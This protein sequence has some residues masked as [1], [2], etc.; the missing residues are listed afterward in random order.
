MATKAAA[1]SGD[2]FKKPKFFDGIVDGFKDFTHF[3]SDV[4]SEMRK[5]VTPSPKEVRVT[6]TVVIIAVFLFA[7]FFF[8]VDAIFNAAIIGPHGILSK[9]GGLQ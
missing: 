6:T 8:I 5:V 2:N 4:R 7:L 3:L 1:A 9:L